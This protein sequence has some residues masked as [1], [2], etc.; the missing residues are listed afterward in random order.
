MWISLMA[1]EK[2]K[3]IQA[4]SSDWATFSWKSLRGEVGEGNQDGPRSCREVEG[5]RGGRGGGEGE[6]TSRSSESGKVRRRK[7]VTK[8]DR[9]RRRATAAA[10]TVTSSPWNERK[11][12]NKKKKT[13]TCQIYG[14]FSTEV[15][16]R[17]TGSARHYPKNLTFFKNF[18]ASTEIQNLHVLIRKNRLKMS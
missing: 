18:L 2:R 3:E 14:F 15:N 9:R 13:L 4:A 7:S 11:E 1:R 8:N 12:G 10:T 5:C 17:H 16:S 6:P